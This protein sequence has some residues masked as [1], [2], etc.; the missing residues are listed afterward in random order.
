MMIRYKSETLGKFSQ[1]CIY[2]QSFFQYENSYFKH[3]KVSPA[4]FENAR[5]VQILAA[6]SICSVQRPRTQKWSRSGPEN[7]LKIFLFYFLAAT[8]NHAKVRAHM[9]HNSLR[10]PLHIYSS[11]L[12]YLLFNCAGFVSYVLSSW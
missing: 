2:W 9:L 3:M 7:C 12:T 1:D 8:S 11:Q 10:L 4:L 5:V 6:E